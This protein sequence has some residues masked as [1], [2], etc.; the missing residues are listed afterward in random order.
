MA[1]KQHA[2]I[3]AVSKILGTAITGSYQTV[4]TF[5]DDVFLL[6]IFNSCDEP[7]H[8]SL[9]GGTTTQLEL[10]GENVAIDLRSN[11]VGVKTPTI[12]VKAVSSIP[13]AGSLRITAVQNS[14]GFI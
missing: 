13:T 9:D 10:E 1:F 12:Q 8:I 14:A 4:A 2:S 3:P 5:Q 6:L 11:E 7:I